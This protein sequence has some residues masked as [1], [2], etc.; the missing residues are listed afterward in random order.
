MSRPKNYRELV[1]TYVN[2]T[3]PIDQRESVILSL[4][5]NNIYGDDRIELV[6][7]LIP[8]LGLDDLY[9]TIDQCNLLIRQNIDRL[10]N[11]KLDNLKRDLQEWARS[12]LKDK[13][14]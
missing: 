2:K 4:V 6:K 7:S 10:L 1:D 11:E 12:E 5:W 14:E 9:S 8:Y 3:V 13:Y